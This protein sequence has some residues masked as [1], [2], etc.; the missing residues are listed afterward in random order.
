MRLAMAKALLPVAFLF[1]GGTAQGGSGTKLK[2]VLV[3]DKS[4]M[5]ANSHLE[6]RRDC[7]AALRE[8]AAEKGF[9][10]T[11]IVQNDPA[12]KIAAEFSEAGL[13]GYQAVIALYNE[14]I[15]AQLDAA[16]KAALEAHVKGGGGLIMVH[17]AQDFIGDW[18]WIK[19][20]LVES[21]YGP[22]GMNQPT[23]NLAHDIEG[24][25]AGT[26]TRGIFSGLA[27][28]SAYLDEFYSFRS[29]PRDS[30]GVTI[31]ATVD[32]RSFSKPING[33]MGDDHPVV[34]T[35]EEGL[36][37]V[38]NFSLG[39]SWSTHNVFAA[40]N[41]YLKR[42]LYGV[43][44]YVAGD[45]A[46][47]SDDSFVEYNPDATRADPAACKTFLPLSLP[48]AAG[49]GRWIS[50]FREAQ[51]GALGIRVGSTGP[52]EVALRDVSG[53]TLHRRQGTGPAD[54]SLPLPAAGGIYFVAG[55]AGDRESR[56]G[57]IK[58]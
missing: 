18:P 36:G 54:F 7:N 25:L 56:L 28:P 45:F 55:K 37:H 23:A 52:Y 32:E 24:T 15:H 34:W 53:R 21:F 1:A 33:P 13:S 8:L 27:A 35:K 42:L 29:S 26:E 4:Q 11:H 17:A 16:S 3:L 9:A 49:K 51:G 44:R 47:C 30:P 22:H 19:A 46:G 5:G 38:V 2:H 31:L 41:G 40:K 48:G 57:Y 6:S 14:G 58:P 50:S 12:A 39:H 10:V 20:A 43:L